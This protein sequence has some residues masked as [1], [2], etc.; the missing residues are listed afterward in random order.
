MKVLAFAVSMLFHPL[1][2]P[3]Y[4][5]FITFNTG[6]VF[7]YIP[8]Y[9]QNMSYL[10]TLLGVTLIPLLCL[11]LL[12]WL[13]LIEGYRLVQKQDRVFP[14]LVTIVGAFIVFYFSR[15]LP[16]SNIVRQFYLIMV[17][18][19]SGFMI[20][21]IRWK[22]SMHMTAIGALC[23][24]VFILG[25]KYLGDVIN[26]LPLLIL[27]S[28]LVASARLYL[29]QHTLPKCMSG[30]LWRRGRGGYHVLIKHDP[31]IAL[32]QLGGE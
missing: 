5:L 27:V 32:S 30:I 25:M 1:L 28:G 11:P 24:F 4:V 21:T 16:Y 29:K 26:L 9:T 20:V 12:K 23:G 15:N 14:V 7:T 13:G 18:M 17:I 22:I 6:T 8:A 2:L 19:L 31:Y 3:L 10:L